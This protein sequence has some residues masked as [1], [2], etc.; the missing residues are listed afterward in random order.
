MDQDWKSLANAE[1]Q[2]VVASVTALATGSLVLPLFFL[3]DL[4]G[5]EEGKPLFPHL[6]HAVYASWALLS[7][8]IFFGIFFQYVSAK[9][10]KN[11]HGGKTI[12][13][14]PA[15]ERWL[16]WSLWLSTLSFLAGL[17]FLL[18]FATT[19]RIAS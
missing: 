9:W 1:Y 4:A 11:A 7:L 2:K 16:D 19:L 15:L 18:R 12:L 10:L 6:S 3:R 17:G 14:G 5:V 8:A 13:S